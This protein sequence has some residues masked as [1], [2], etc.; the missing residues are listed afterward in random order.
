MQKI[1]IDTNILVS[2]L[3]SSNKDSATVRILDIIL[4]EIAIPIINEAIHSEYEDVLSRKKFG[5]SENLVKTLMS[6]I[7]RIAIKAKPY[8]S[9]EYFIDEDDRPFYEAML[10]HDD[11]VLI[12][13]NTKHFLRM[14]E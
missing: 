4:S 14:K 8:S 7:K 12:T 11:A 5:F 1:V 6:E 2:A 9:N 3:L 10:S 13:G